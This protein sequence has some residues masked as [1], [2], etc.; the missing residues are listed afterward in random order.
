MHYEVFVLSLLSLVGLLMLEAIIIAGLTR[1]EHTS[2]L[3][4]TDL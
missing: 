1:T 2:P 3:D 4:D